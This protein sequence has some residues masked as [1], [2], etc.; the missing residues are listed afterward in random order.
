M[1][2]GEIKETYY[3][4]TVRIFNHKKEQPQLVFESSV[5]TESFEKAHHTAKHFVSLLEGAGFTRFGHDMTIDLYGVFYDGMYFNKCGASA[6]I[7]ICRRDDERRKE[8][9]A[10]QR[11]EEKEDKTWTIYGCRCIGEDTDENRI[12]MPWYDIFDDIDDYEP[13]PFD[14]YNEPFIYDKEKGIITC[15]HKG[16]A[17]QL[18]EYLIGKTHQLKLYHM[19]RDYGAT[20]NDLTSV[21]CNFRDW[22]IKDG[23]PINTYSLILTNLP[24]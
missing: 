4:I 3:K 13:L 22:V 5:E 7:G 10:E 21:H 16:M 11:K 24:L 9:P 14:S 17:L 20:D 19:V 15:N 6:D 23:E 1:P 12:A 2:Y 8:D 18:W